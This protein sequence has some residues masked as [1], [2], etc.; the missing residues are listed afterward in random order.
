MSD[1]MTAWISSTK[2]KKTWKPE[3]KGGGNSPKSLELSYR[4]PNYK[5][6]AVKGFG[7]LEVISVRLGFGCARISALALAP[8][9][10]Q[11]QQSGLRAPGFGS[12]DWCLRSIRSDRCSW[13]YLSSAG[14]V[15]AL[16]KDRKPRQEPCVR[17]RRRE[18]RAQ[19]PPCLCATRHRCLFV[20]AAAGPGGGLSLSVWRPAQSHTSR[21]DPYFRRAALNHYEKMSGDA[22]WRTTD[23]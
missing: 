15:P 6:H 5:R 18:D 2:T 4:L 13:S 23:R 20:G 1:R 22:N 19:Q 9:H 7:T 3:S 8:P 21:V 10:R 17:C 11:L 12:R 16:E 14:C